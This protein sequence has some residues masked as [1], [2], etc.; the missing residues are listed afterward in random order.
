M[1]VSF[2]LCIV[3]KACCLSALCTAYCG[4]P[5]QPLLAHRH[6]T[7]QGTCAA[8]LGTQKQRNQ[9]EIHPLAPLCTRRR[10]LAV[11]AESLEGSPAKE[12]R[13]QLRSS[14]ATALTS[15]W[16]VCRSEGREQRSEGSRVRASSEE[17]SAQQELWVRFCNCFCFR[18]RDQTEL[19]G[20]TTA[21]HRRVSALGSGHGDAVCVDVIRCSSAT[22]Q[23]HQHGFANALAHGW[24]LAVLRHRPPCPMRGVTSETPVDS[25][26]RCRI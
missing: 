21:G 2:C 10:V 8:A 14:H 20:L 4:A 13:T 23:A 19:H 5:V 9:R 12:C 7:L 6:S 17:L 26:H 16:T 1:S 11:Y 25:T 3:E 18:S 15:N 22:A 24:C